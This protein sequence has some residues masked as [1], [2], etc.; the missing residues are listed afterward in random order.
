M[1]VNRNPYESW[2]ELGANSD[3]RSTDTQMTSLV[4]QQLSQP[5]YLRNSNRVNPGPRR[6]HRAN[7]ADSKDQIPHPFG[8]EDMWGWQQWTQ[9]NPSDL[10]EVPE[11]ENIFEAIDD[12]NVPGKTYDPV[13]EVG[14]ASF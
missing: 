6:N 11:A 14:G 2:Q 10:V 7:V 5:E 3:Y 13:G 12:V 9:V 1:A 8:S 4:R